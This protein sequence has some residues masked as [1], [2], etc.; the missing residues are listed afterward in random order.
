MKTSIVILPHSTEATVALG[1]VRQF[2]ESHRTYQIF[3]KVNGK[4]SDKGVVT[5]NYIDSTT[6]I[7]K[8]FPIDSDGNPITGN[9]YYTPQDWLNIANAR[10]LPS[11]RL[12]QNGVTI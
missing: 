4:I 2:L 5:L 7:N 8:A 11:T 10:N 3:I 1:A 6:D 9:G 12:K